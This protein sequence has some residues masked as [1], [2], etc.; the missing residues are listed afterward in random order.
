MFT[1]L[2]KH[3]HTRTI[4]AKTW[5]NKYPKGYDHASFIMFHSL[6]IMKRSY[7]PSKQQNYSFFE[8][9]W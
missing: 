8:N 6:V 5:R 2:G 7:T 4:S 1:I 3:K 9:A